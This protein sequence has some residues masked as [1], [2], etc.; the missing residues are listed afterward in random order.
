MVDP[1]DD[2]GDWLHWLVVDIPGYNVSLGIIKAGYM[3]SLPSEGSGK[4]I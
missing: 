3:R 2:I 4:I 1:D